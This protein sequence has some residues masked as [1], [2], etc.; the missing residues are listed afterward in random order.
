MI[1]LCGMVTAHD[2]FGTDLVCIPVDH[3]NIVRCTSY[4][5]GNLRF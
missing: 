4:Y 2:L 3:Q 5:L 1:H